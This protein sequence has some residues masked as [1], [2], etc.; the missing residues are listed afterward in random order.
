VSQGKADS[1]QEHQKQGNNEDNDSCFAPSLKMK[2]EETGAHSTHPSRI[3]ERFMT[4]KAYVPPHRRQRQ[5]QETQHDTSNADDAKQFFLRSVSY[6]RCINLRKRPDK[7]RAFTNE[8]RH[9][10]EA[11]LEKTER[12]DAID[13][14]HVEVSHS[15]DVALEWDSTENSKYSSKVTPGKKT[16]SEGEIGCA[17]SHVALWRE[18]ADMEGS[19][20]PSTITM[21]ILEDD[22]SFSSFKGKPRFTRAFQNAW[23]Q[24]PADWDILYLG[25][26]DR[27]ERV[28][29]DGDATTRMNT[30]PKAYHPLHDPQVQLFRPEYGYHTHAYVLKKT[31][32]RALLEQLPVVGPLDVWLADNRWFH[33]KVFCAVIANE[34]W[35]RADG[36]YEGGLLVRQN[37]GRGSTSDVLQS[38]NSK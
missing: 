16:L 14:A 25:F 13:G 4:S 34:G 5:E 10:G 12:F 20:D 7:W 38:A 6:S 33:L 32:A 24:L 37:R 23:K 11:F 22:V 8:A 9:V 28:Y 26:S 21:L 1:G 29:V 31:A 30:S 3:S 27:G 17:L 35:R 19:D 18:L 15:R 2:I 36:S